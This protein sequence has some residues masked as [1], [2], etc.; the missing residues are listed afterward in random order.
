MTPPPQVPSFADISNAESLL[1]APNIAGNLLPM[2]LLPLERLVKSPAQLQQL[3]EA[4]KGR[5]YMLAYL[6]GE[7]L[8][9]WHVERWLYHYRWVC[10]AGP[11]TCA[12][13]MWMWGVQVNGGHSLGASVAPLIRHCS[14]CTLCSKCSA[15]THLCHL[16]SSSCRTEPHI[17]VALQEGAKPRDIL[18]AVLEA[19]CLR[20]G[21]QQA[22]HT[23]ALQ[24]QPQQQAGDNSR[25]SSSS[26]S[27]SNRQPVL[28]VVPLTAGLV[29]PQLP[30]ARRRAEQLVDKLLADVQ[31]EGWQTR[32]FL[33]STA[34]KEGY[35]LM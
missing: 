10:L 5:A 24:Q 29:E 4:Y 33:L 6:P 26:S 14:T 2:R 34:E 30:K 28:P 8:P 17:A 13:C 12:W 32:T 35:A 27:S 31:Q 7:Q 25:S 21:V 23:T 16:D 1:G 18:M 19:G 15:A 20:Q 11:C 3:M 9:W 22:L